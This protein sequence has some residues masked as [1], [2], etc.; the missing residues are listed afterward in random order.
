MKPAIS[1]SNECGIS[2]LSPTALK[3]MADFFKVLSQ[4]TRLQIICSLKYGAKNVTEILKATSLGQ[5]N[6]SKIQGL[7]KSLF[8]IQ[9]KR[10]F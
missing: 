3:L 2:E 6:V 8:R 9:C 7:A 10:Y 1:N 4:T 5:A